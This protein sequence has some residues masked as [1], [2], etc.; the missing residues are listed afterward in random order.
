VLSPSWY[1]DW[2]GQT[3][4][5]VGGGPSAADADLGGVAGRA[6]CIVIN[7]GYR[8][9]PWADALYAADAHWWERQRGCREFRGMRIS[10]SDQA[11]KM[12]PGIQQVS[13]RRV[14]CFIME[15][16]GVVSAGSDEFGVGANSGFQAI[17]LAIQFGT[18]RIVLVGFDM[19]V[20]H[21]VHWH[22]PHGGGLNNPSAE[23]IER[24]RRVLDRQAEPLARAGI[25]VINASAISALRNYPKM[26]LGEAIGHRGAPGGG[27]REVRAGL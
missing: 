1:P 15:P 8:L 20:G 25:T 14:S 22:G 2:A 12:Y 18:R 27:A 17:N 13:L 10:Q 23:G 24:W 9:A 5:V 3:A 16:H 26:K 19:T 6:R 11:A 21:G 7:E 4:I